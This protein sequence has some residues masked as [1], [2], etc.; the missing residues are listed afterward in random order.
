MDFCKVVANVR[1]IIKLVVN[2]VPDILDNQVYHALYGFH[3]GDVCMSNNS[4]VS[5]H[6]IPPIYEKHPLFHVFKHTIHHIIDMNL[7]QSIRS[8]LELNKVIFLLYHDNQQIINS[9]QKDLSNTII[10][11]SFFQ[12]LKENLYE[13]DRSC[14]C[15]FKVEKKKPIT[16]DCCQ[17]IK[18]RI[19]KILDKYN[20]IK[21]IQPQDLY[22]A[23]VERKGNKDVASILKSLFNIEIEN[24]TQNNIKNIAQNTKTIISVPRSYNKP[25]M[26]SDLEEIVHARR[27]QQNYFRPEGIN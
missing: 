1:K 22:E 16:E 18:R 13:R 26:L 6:Y 23:I 15:Q 3:E 2:S 4:N 5:G 27:S 25:K 17:E 7:G 20:E 21:I 11:M 14:G 9:F 8:Y 10:L 24:K 12:G 19:L